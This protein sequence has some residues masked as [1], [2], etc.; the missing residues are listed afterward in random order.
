MK[1]YFY[2][3]TA[4]LFLSGS[5]LFANG[6]SLN[7][8]GPR[9]LGMGG[10]MVGLANDYTTIY[11]NPAGLRNLSGTYIGGYFTGIM[12]MGTYKYDAAGIDAETKSNIYPAPGLIGHWQC[13]LSD[14]GT[15]GLGVYVPAGLGAEWD[16][17]DFT[18][19]AGGQNLNWSSQ[20]GV[21]NIS[22]AFAYQL[23]DQL[24]LGF[25]VNIFYGMFDME[26]GSSGAQYEESS[27]G[28][29][30][31][32]TLGA[33]FKVNE[34]ISLGASF[35][36]KTDVKMSG[37]AKNPGMALVPA[38]MGGPY[39]TKSDFDR[40]VSWPMWIGGGVAVKPVEGLTLA[41]DVQYSQWSES[42]KEFQTEFDNAGWAAV[43]GATGDDKFILK[44]EDATQIR[45]GAEYMVNEMI[46]VRG[47]FYTDPA[48]AP[49]E[50]YNFLFPSID[51][52]GITGGA[53]INISGVVVDLGAEYLIGSER[54]IAPTTENV[55]GKHNMNIFAFSIGT[56]FAI[57]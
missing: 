15:V 30:Y 33:H 22:P 29:G 43:T 5:T 39:P 18:A 41:L 8:L 27:S 7:S 55:P 45:F 36:T 37:E 50:T 16:G 21:I 48:P 28:F 44:W 49:D 34:M 26:N 31:G 14:K 9:A 23:S 19:F 20:V 4:A 57:K 38:A 25:A 54:D 35:R 56:G 47:G 13:M 40:D 12:P 1:K 32:V 11:W 53:S 3:L 6:L 52:N 2:L 42:E 46:T 10:A 24:A 51:Y 17:A